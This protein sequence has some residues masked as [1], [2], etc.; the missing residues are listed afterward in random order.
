ME[1]Y[2]KGAVKEEPSPSPFEDKK[3]LITM[4]VNTGSKI[5]NLMGFALTK[6]KD[7]TMREI[8]WYGSGDAIA[9]TI[10]CA[11]IVKRKMKKLQQI[12]KLRYKKIEEYWEPKMEGLERL[13]MNKNIPE[14][15]IL[16]SKDPLDSSEPGYQPPGNLEPFW[17]DVVV[18]KNQNSQRQRGRGDKAGSQSGA[19]ALAPRNKNKKHKN[20]KYGEQVVK[21]AKNI[22]TESKKVQT[23]LSKDNT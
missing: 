4:K 21:K 8:C 9:K 19:S 1:N 16:L 11:E 20:P 18:K 17:N 6:M 15:F 23:V 10:T 13:R 14:I 5:R 2:D 7:E 12:S 3:D 22:E